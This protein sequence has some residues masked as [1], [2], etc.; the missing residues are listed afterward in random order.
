[1]SYSPAFLKSDIVPFPTLN[2]NQRNSFN[3][4]NLD[5]ND[6]LLSYDNFSLLHN[7]FRKF[8]FYTATNIDGK[9]IK[10]IKRKELFDGN[11]DKW[12]KDSRIPDNHQFGTELYSA[13]KSDF[14]RGH[15]TKREDVQWGIDI[16]SAKKAAE[17]TFFYTNAIPQHKKL[18]RGIWLKLE[19]YILHHET[20]SKNLKIILFTGP[21]LRNQDPEFVTPINGMPIKLPTL[22]WK[23][24]YYENSENELMRVSFIT[25]QQDILEKNRVIKPIIVRTVDRLPEK[26]QHNFQ[27]FKA[28]ET[29]QTDVSLIESLTNLTFHKAIEIFKEKRPVR[30]IEQSTN[31]RG[32][33]DTVI[34]KN[35]T[36]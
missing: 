34:I 9:L 13:E 12:T 14:D 15:M 8:P 25:N 3:E 32:L 17:S 10:E 21:V 24:I 36:L 16:E 29:Y 22:F 20:I 7:P 18:N 23:V 4:E 30:L 26:S 19:N 35:I 33:T 5:V 31:V 6:Y 1:M 28:A 2:E 27:K 11:G